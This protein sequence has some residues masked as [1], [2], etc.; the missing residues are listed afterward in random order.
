MGTNP[1]DMSITIRI[2]QDGQF[3]QLQGKRSDDCCPIYGCE[4]DEG[5]PERLKEWINKNEGR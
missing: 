2:V 4:L 1:I 5:E 3:I